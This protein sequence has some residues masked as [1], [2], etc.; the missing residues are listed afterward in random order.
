LRATLCADIARN[1]SF[2]FVFCRVQ[3]ARVANDMGHVNAAA[4]DVKGGDAA[5]M[6]VNKFRFGYFADHVFS[7]SVMFVS[8]IV[9]LSR[10]GQYAIPILKLVEA[11]FWTK[12]KSAT[13]GRNQ[14]MQH[15]ARPHCA[16]DLPR[17]EQIAVY[18]KQSRAIVARHV[19]NWP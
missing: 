19:A 6:C 1:E 12:R 15:G 17:G 18:A 5:L 7:L 3:F 14:A 16:S 11:I 2:S 8:T 4:V 13:R 9:I 10:S